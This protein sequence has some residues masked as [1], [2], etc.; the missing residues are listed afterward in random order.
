MIWVG[1]KIIT[2]LIFWIFIGVGVS[3]GQDSS[4]VT[5]EDYESLHAEVI[6]LRKIKEIHQQQHSMGEKIIR[7]GKSIFLLMVQPLKE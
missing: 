5:Q 4:T 7:W 1:G 6:E 3:E 2:A